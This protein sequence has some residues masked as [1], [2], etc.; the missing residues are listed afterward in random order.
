MTPT[1][2]QLKKRPAL[3]FDS[4]S[5]DTVSPRITLPNGRA[6]LYEDIYCNGWV[7]SNLDDWHWYARTHLE[8]GGWL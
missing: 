5:D 4:Y 8:F 2:K 1:L 6:W 3:W 7:L